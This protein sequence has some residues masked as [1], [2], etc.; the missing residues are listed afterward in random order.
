MK[1][2]K[3]YFIHGFSENSISLCCWSLLRKTGSKSLLLGH[4]NSSKRFVAP[5]PN[6]RQE[7]SQKSKKKNH[8]LKILK[9]NTEEHKIIYINNQKNNTILMTVGITGNSE[10]ENREQTQ[11]RTN[12]IKG[13]FQT[14]AKTKTKVKIISEI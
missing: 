7:E 9:E 5:I 1:E 4:Q 14:A 2:E 6:C 8:K 10:A 11:A 13:N 3:V 12:L